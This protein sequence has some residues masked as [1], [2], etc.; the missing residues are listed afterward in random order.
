MVSVRNVS[1]CCFEGRLYDPT[2]GLSA[3][4][5]CDPSRTKRSAYPPQ[6]PNLIAR[7]SI[8]PPSFDSCQE[9]L[10]T[11]ARRCDALQLLPS[12]ATQRQRRSPP[13]DC[14]PILQSSREKQLLSLAWK[15]GASAAA[16]RAVAL[17][18]CARERS[19]PKGRDSHRVSRTRAFPGPLESWLSRQP[20]TN[21]FYESVRDASL[22]SR[23]QVSTTL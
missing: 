4:N 18:H 2:G 17:S 22:A 14:Q 6:I 23:G 12:A 8:S 20:H 10:I 15:I 19:S 16:F 9:S 5:A 3:D 1:V 11:L 21:P 13:P 7:R